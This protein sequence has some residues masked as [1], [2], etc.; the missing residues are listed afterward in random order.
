MELLYLEMQI[1]QL[2]QSLSNE[3]LASASR[4][5]LDH[6]IQSIGQSVSQ[7][8]EKTAEEQLIGRCL[9]F[10]EDSDPPSSLNASIANLANHVPL[11]S[12]HPDDQT[13]FWRQ[14]KTIFMENSINSI[15]TS[16][17][18]VMSNAKYKF[19][20]EE[21][22]DSIDVSNLK[23]LQRVV[24]DMARI[25]RDFSE[26]G[27]PDAACDQIRSIRQSI[28]AN[29]S[30]HAAFRDNLEKES[31]NIDALEAYFWRL[32]SSRSQVIGHLTES[33]IRNSK[34]LSDINQVHEEIGHF[35][36]RITEL[37]SVKINSFQKLDSDGIPQ[38]SY[39][40][41]SLDRPSHEVESVLSTS[42][43]P[44]VSDLLN[45]CISSEENLQTTMKKT[46]D[47]AEPLNN[48]FCESA[49]LLVS[50]CTALEKFHS[51]TMDAF[52]QTL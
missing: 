23:S 2:Q 47:A 3:S 40:V 11:H 8:E 41:S 51:P 36:D 7:I 29:S 26:Q 44:P 25:I 13:E 14:V 33:I 38:A 28:D 37:I 27:N 17:Y 49:S 42:L 46:R 34:T 48:D 45:Q 1:R 52:L 4:V 35:C 20:E 30:L 5:I 22:V 43:L 6:T 50:E 24:L 31:P 12:N 15:R 21:P 9:N 19:L 18:N 16:I 32:L 39:H 10:G